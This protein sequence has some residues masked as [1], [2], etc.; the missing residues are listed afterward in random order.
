MNNK[1][2]NKNGTEYI[3]ALIKDAI[4]NETRTATVKG[5]HEID[6]AVRL[7]SNFTLILEDCHLK[8]KD[9]CYSNVF[10]NE[11]NE[12]D[13]GRTVAGAD[14]NI[15]IIGR[16]EAILDGGEY[17][18]L[19]EKTPIEKRPA[20]LYKNNLILFTNVEGFKISGISCINQRWWATNFI[21]CRNGY[22]GNIDFCSN[23]TCV[24]ENGNIYHGFS[25]RKYSEQ[26]KEIL[27]KNSDGID[28]RQGC[29]DILIENISGFTEDDTIALTGLNGRLENHFKVEGLST[30]ICNVTIKNVASAA[31]CS[32]VRLLNQG[33]VRLHDITVDGVTDTS[34]TDTHLE[35]GNYAVRV[36]DKHLY[37]E[38][39]STEDE[40][41]NITVKNVLAK[42][43]A[44]LVLAGTIKNLVVYGIE[45]QNG[46]KMLID[47]RGQE[48]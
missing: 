45:C 11:H 17:N 43:E 12:T 1:S 27:V 2:F 46:C 40:T 16:G 6:T 13:I 28:L 42:S 48:K 15:N 5:A 44:A 29:H 21:F 34:D 36:G 30:D 19:G 3:N 39:H 37:G 35:S 7:P 18:G 31:F 10:V 25:R 32:N 23:D 33:G 14:R 9:G 8:L 41:Y 22:I 26:S 4:E 38:R 20:P 47:H 24:D